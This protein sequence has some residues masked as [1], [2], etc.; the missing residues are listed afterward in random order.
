MTKTGKKILHTIILAL[1][2]AAF[3]CL[4]AACGTDTPEDNAVTYTVTVKKD[5][6]TPAEGVSVQIR[7][8]G[9]GFE[10][11][12]TDAN[13]KVTFELA[14]DSY[15]VVLAK[16]PDHYSV[17]ESASLSVTA[18]SRDLTVTLEK[19]FFYTVKLVNPDK[20]PFYAPGIMVG[21]C[22][23]EGSCL[24]PVLIDENGVA[25]IEADPGDYHVQLP[26]LPA[27]YTF[28]KDGAGYYRGGNFSATDTEMTITIYTATVANAV[29]P[30][31]EA[32]KKTYSEG[33]PAYNSSFQRYVSYKLTKEL[34][35]DEVAYFCID[36]EISGRYN[37]F[38]NSEV[39]FLSNG[40][41]FVAGKDGNYLSSTLICRE[42][43]PYFFKAINNGSRPAKAEFVITAPFSSYISQHGK[44]G[45]LDVVV[46]KENTNAIISFS[47]SE[48]G[49]YRVSVTGEAPAALSVSA[50]NSGEFIEDA[51]ADGEY[52]SNPSDSF[53]AYT[54]N[55]TSGSYIYIAITAKAE[56]YPA[57]LNVNI[58]K[59][60]E[61][62]DTHTTVEVKETLTQYA[63]PAGK[64]LYGVPMNGTAK[65]V[66]NSAD[67][68]YHL[69]TADGAVVVVN[70]TGSLDVSRFEEGC[71]LAYM[72]LVNG[73][74]A[75]YRFITKRES[76]EDTLDYRLFLRGFEEY[77][78]TNGTHGPVAS[79]PKEITAQTYYAKFV[80]EDGVY[81]LT[82]ELKIFLEKFY[83]ANAAAFSW[84]IPA[85]VEAENAWLFP[86]YYYDGETEADAIV[87]DYQFLSLTEEG[88]TYVVGDEYEGYCTAVV[89][90]LTDGKLTGGSVIV[91]VRKNGSFSV[92]PY[93]SV[94]EVY[95]ESN[96]YDSGTWT[97]DGT[98]AFACTAGTLTYSDGTFAYI[99]GEITIV[100][101]A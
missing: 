23:F 74:L 92:L 36:A 11:K 18:D 80:N 86:C 60:A 77:D 55:V 19:S 13:G 7:K 100:F 38:T 42:G 47:P 67:K 82:E 73:Q 59:T 15:E 101:K 50:S 10:K 6:A 25:E 96:A 35:A 5:A 76:G 90:G 81:P 63:K 99:D 4:F 85:N 49:T 57:K 95:D 1:C 14:P 24:T 37:I 9:A 68:Y 62:A 17:P 79:I 28:D 12:S 39:L 8:G 40:T 56:E 98:Y 54:S 21:I 72:E 84:Q 29:A 33:T 48:A 2:L 16:L 89:D 41:E 43:Q 78:Y 3:A 34:K 61:V 69:G 45:V 27:C 20:T 83:E 64:E 93:S 87:K 58:T 94:N 75:T 71:A 53:V 52:V 32:E 46:G 30:M 22:T 31:T 88:R 91:R 26:E 70:I 51:L 44:G 66:Y 97:N 65:L